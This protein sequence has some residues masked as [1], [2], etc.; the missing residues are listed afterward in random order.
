MMR[1]MLVLPLKVQ[2]FGRR[3]AS[4][5]RLAAVLNRASAPEVP[6]LANKAHLL[7]VDD[8]ANTLASLSRAFRLAGHEATVCDNA[9]K[10]LQ[11][12]KAHNFDLILLDVGIPG[13]GGFA[14]LGEFKGQG[15]TTPGV[16]IVRQGD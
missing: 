12:A 8:E 6:A 7:I 10:A 11:L 16:K 14:L 13:R 5:L 3:S 2:A 1:Q 15:G 9:D 4:A